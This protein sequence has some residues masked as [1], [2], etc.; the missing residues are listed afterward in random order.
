MPFTKDQIA[1]YVQMYLARKVETLAND[2]IIALATFTG[3]TSDDLDLLELVLAK[4]RNNLI[5]EVERDIM[6]FYR[7]DP[8][9]K[10]SDA[11]SQKK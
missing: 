9:P 11:T 10:D 8:A 5:A 6:R 1:D 3:K 7:V 2:Y 4:V